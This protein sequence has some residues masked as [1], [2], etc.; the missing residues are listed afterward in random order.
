M[1]DAPRFLNV[2][3]GDDSLVRESESVL[4]AQFPTN[5]GELQVGL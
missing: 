3:C 1:T 5:P 4:G 2:V